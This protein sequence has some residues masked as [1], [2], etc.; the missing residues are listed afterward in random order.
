MFGLLT[1]PI[2][3]ALKGEL[4]NVLSSL[5]LNPLISV[6]MWQLLEISQIIP[7]SSV[8]LSSSLNPSTS[9]FG[10]AGLGLG[11]GHASRNDI[12]S[13][14][15]EVEAREE[16]YPMLRGFLSLIRT[17]VT[18]STPQVPDN[19]GVGVRPKSAPLGFQPYMNF[20]INH[21]YLKFLFRSYKSSHEKW[22]ICTDLLNIFYQFVVR[23][24]IK[25][26]L[27]YFINHLHF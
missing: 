3:V 12:K 1:C 10:A 20:L 25:T 26:L 2:P 19:L 6:N 23:F 13:E 15:E 24:K 22:L 8:A 5:S 4:F 21:V 14:L 16:V 11:L 9:F 7:T 18:H 17:L 27:P